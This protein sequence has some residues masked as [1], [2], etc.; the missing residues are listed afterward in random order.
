MPSMSIRIHCDA[1]PA[2]RALEDLA[3]LVRDQGGLEL[4]RDLLVQ[5]GELFVEGVL[6]LDH[7]FQIHSD[8]PTSGAGDVLLS[9][10]PSE[11]FLQ[12]LSALR[13]GPYPCSRHSRDWLSR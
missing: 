6:C 11:L 12:F 5:F 9:F 7:A 3:S 13:S 1:D 10:E 4:D 8:A 2:L